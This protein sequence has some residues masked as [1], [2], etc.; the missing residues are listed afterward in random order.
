M[1][2][3]KISLLNSWLMKVCFTLISAFFFTLIFVHPSCAETYQSDSIP[4]SGFWWPVISGGL[5]TG[6]G[7]RMHPSP[8]DKYEMLTN[9]YSGGSFSYWYLY[10]S[11]YY[12]PGEKSWVGLC[13]YWANA[14][15]KESYEIL[16]SS[17]NNIVF[18]VGDKKGLLVLCHDFGLLEVADGNDP[19]EF[20]F[21]LLD[22]IK[23]QKKAFIAELDPGLEVW[24]YPVYRYDMTSSRTG[25]TEAI[26]VTI[27]YADDAVSPDYMG[28][29]EKQK[30]YTY[31][32]EL[33]AGNEIVGG[34]WSGNSE[35]D[36]PDTLVYPL[37]TTAKCPYIDCDRVRQIARAKDDDLER[38][39]NAVV[40]IDP[41]TYNLILLNEDRYEVNGLLAGNE[42]YLEVKKDDSSDE[43]MVVEISDGHGDPVYSRTLGYNQSMSYYLKSENPPYY[44]SITQDDYDEPNIYTLSI[45]VKTDYQQRVA[46]I[47]KNGEWSC[48]VL[49]N[50]S[51][52]RVD[53]LSLVTH[54]KDGSPLQTV[55]GPISLNPNEKQVMLFDDLNWRQHEYWNIDSLA[56]V[57][58]QPLHMVN[59]FG[60]KNRPM[61]CFVQGKAVGTHLVIPDIYRGSGRYM[62]GKIFNESFADAPVT[63]SV[64]SA[65]GQ[66]QYDVNQTL[67]ANGTYSIVPGTVPFNKI[68]DGGWIDIV[69]TESM[70][71]SGYQYLQDT[72]GNK[73]SLETLFALVIDAS[74]KFVPHITD[75]AGNWKTLLTLINPTDKTNSINFHSSLAGE[76]HTKDLNL[77]FAPYE[78]R[79][80]D[81]TAEFGKLPGD[82]LYHSVY[83]ITGQHSIDGYYTYRPLSGYDEASFPLLGGPDFQSDLVLPHS[84]GQNGHWWTAAGIC[85]LNNYSLQV[86]L[87]PYDDS[88][89]LIE[90]HVATLTI[91][92]GAYVVFT[93]HS[94]FGDV[95]SDIA[96]IKL[97]SIEPYGA[98][99]GGFYLFGNL[100]GNNS[101]DWTVTWLSGANM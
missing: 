9:G 64:Y 68:P 99:I 16:P 54:T 56:L 41:G 75:P 98:P 26:T 31:T 88:G 48:F 23:D 77:E 40:P 25:L 29:R 101:K 18:R 79:V 72:T 43:D 57:S 69:S 80:L 39:D 87:E 93:V 6:M 14:S 21:W 62:K 37:Q 22:Y 17:E 86:A 85:N 11:N 35:D 7:Y 82:A 42:V 50:T 13:A 55:F 38:P 27:Y 46:Y 89:A 70:P 73:Y 97:H 49:T 1:I 92:S 90:D 24:Y 71:L 95:I 61:G 19:V 15:V 3:N 94:I 12:A 34:D 59:L 28:T 4:W 44:I 76:D 32:L 91:K 78:K 8:I 51:D 36:H 2:K 30:T 65:D 67:S 5:A 20:H 81:L 84:A 66:W 58:N 60:Y 83:E 63:M 45:D 96:F 52:T 33:N 53:D 74:T 10:E 47:P 100:Y